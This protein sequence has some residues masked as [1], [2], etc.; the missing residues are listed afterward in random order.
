MLMQRK[1]SNG[2]ASMYL[3]LMDKPSIDTGHRCAVCGRYA[4]NTHHI[5]PRSLGGVSGPT[6][7]LCGSG[8]TGCHGMAET[9]R[10][11]FRYEDGWE[12]L[13]TASPTSYFTAL[14]MGGWERMQ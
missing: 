14:G 10:L 8:T 4:T 1:I 12:Y 9:K 2:M 11:H 5:V 3:V 7:R 13:Y 6:V